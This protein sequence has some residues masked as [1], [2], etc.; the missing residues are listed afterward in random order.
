MD[1]LTFDI[2]FESL[3]EDGFPMK[4]LAIQAKVNNKVL[5]SWKFLAIDLL[6]LVDST[7]QSGE[8]YIWTCN[9]GIPECAGIHQGVNV[10]L[11]ENT[12]NWI[13][14][15]LPEDDILKFQFNRGLYN[16]KIDELWKSYVAYYQ[17]YISS[18]IEFELC[19]GIRQG[20]FERRIEKNN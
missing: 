2:L 10:T 15:D 1:T 3:P 13:V 16:S 12:V 5:V 6:E 9:C 18:N 8:F 4:Q 17:S 20:E 14:Y 7:K 11:A 19:P